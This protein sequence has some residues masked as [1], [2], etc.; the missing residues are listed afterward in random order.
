MACGL[1]SAA[2]AVD[3]SLTALDGEARSFGLGEWT[4]LRVGDAIARDGVVETHGRLLATRGGDALDFAPGAKLRLEGETYVLVRLFEGSLAATVEPDKARPFMVMTTFAQITTEGAAFGVTAEPFGAT[5]A[6]REGAVEVTDLT[7]H[8]TVEV[9]QGQVLHLRAGRAGGLAA[10]GYP[11]LAAT[12]DA[13]ADARAAPPPEV[14][15]KILALDHLSTGAIR[16]AAR[17]DER[18]AEE[19]LQRL[20]DEKRKAGLGK[21]DPRTFAIAAAITRELLTGFEYEP[22]PWDDSFQWTTVENGEVRLK[23]LWKIFLHLE[24]PESYEFWLLAFMVCLL[25]GALAKAITD[26]SG[27]GVF[28]STVLVMLAFA[29]AILVRDLFFRNGANL[30]VEPYLTVVMMLTAMTAFLLG[31]VATARRSP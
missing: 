15:T 21:A 26:K 1:N 3:W 17:G 22:E 14:L 24:A 4:A 12:G 11:A 19:A 20:R 9:K 10:S 5:V 31:G 28:G 2:L 7:T 13:L 8:A 6:V 18:L 25:L 27:F 23:P 30:S 29:L 16:P